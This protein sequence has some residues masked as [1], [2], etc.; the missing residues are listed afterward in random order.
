MKYIK[1]DQLLLLLILFI[2]LAVYFP[3]MGSFAY[4]LRS[5]YSDLVITHYPN[6]VYIRNAILED[7]SI[8]LWSQS[9]FS[10]YPFH[11]DPLTGYLYPPNW[12]TYILPLPFAFNALIF[13]HILGGSIG[14]YIFLRYKKLSRWSAVAGALAF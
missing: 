5:E 7:R 6:A 3:K 12:I 10:G 14:L 4:P 8:P 1:K 11:A 13:A 9:I 2:P